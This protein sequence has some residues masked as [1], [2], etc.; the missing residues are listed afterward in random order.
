MASS[1]S[2]VVDVSQG[3]QTISF[4][5]PAR[6]TAGGSTTLSASGGASA[7]A[8][9]FS[10]DPS[11]EAGACTLPGDTV[12]Y[13]RA[14]NCVIDANEAANADYPAAPQV[15]QT[16]LVRSAT[17]STA[18][19]A[20][21][22]VAPVGQAV[23][24]TAT[25]TDGSGPAP[26]GTVTLLKGRRRCAPAWPC[27][28]KPLTGQRAWSRTPRRGAS[29]S[30]PPTTAARPRWRRRV[31]VAVDVVQGLQTISFTAPATRIYG[32]TFSPSAT[33]SSGLAVSFSIDASSTAGSCSLAQTSGLVS[34]T[35]TGTCVVDADQAGDADY[36]SAPTISHAIS[37]SP[38]PL[39][40]T[41]SSPAMTYGA[42]APAVTPVYSGFVGG[43]SASSLTT[44]PACST[45]ATSSS[46]VGSYPSSCSGAVDA[47]YD[48]SYVAGT[49]T[50]NPAL[51]SVPPPPLHDH[52]Y[53]DHHRPDH[54]RPDHH[55]H[56]QQ[57]RDHHRHDH[58]RW[59]DQPTHT[60][61]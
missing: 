58:G 25:V 52:H 32:S 48:I 41:A 53:H 5:A 26:T 45:T 23:T 51:A 47:N 8:V 18:V 35:G 46:P 55:R 6:G 39:T 15:T 2:V 22:A 28:P 16:I 13:T 3:T 17:T 29:W 19:T 34:F 7:N 60:P 30:R 43:D 24:Y 1:G 31:P 59:A 40:V 4:T 12:R 54:H 50:V 20:S 44:A 14:G 10:L 21:P 33:T 42:A 56:D 38:A 49:V 36:P 9:V 27:R 37:V 57:R 61:P 11:S